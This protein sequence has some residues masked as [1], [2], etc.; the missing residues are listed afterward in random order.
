MRARVL[1]PIVALAAA[2]AGCATNAATNSDGPGGSSTG[3][4]PAPAGLSGP[5]DN[6]LRQMFPAGVRTSGVLR[7]AADPTYPPS[8]FKDTNGKIVGMLPDF[9]TAITSRAGLKI[10]WVQVPFDG[11]LAGL[12][13]HRFDASWSAWSI[14]AEREQQL[15]LVAYIKGG[16]SVLVKKGNPAS[17]NA[18]TD[19]C[20]RTVAAETGTTQ[21][22]QVVDELQQACAAASKHP[23]TL[24]RLPQQTDVNQAVAT[25]RADALL[26]D[27]SMVGYQAKIHPGVFETVPTILVQPVDAAVAVPKANPQL[28]NALAAGFNAIIADGTYGKVLAR[29]NNSNAALAKAELN[30]ARR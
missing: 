1:I 12:A 21:A 18:S 3:L 7:L 13:A 15:N 9:A 8:T 30:P 27:N 28:A 17:I 19:L 23:M 26:A 11:M 6:S 24:L 5:V 16:T 20:G 25:G 22:Q 10:E 2:L 14:T 4:S 29:W